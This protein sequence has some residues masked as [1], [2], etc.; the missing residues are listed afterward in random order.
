MTNPYVWS[1]LGVLLVLGV[2][3]Y[4]ILN[5]WIMPSYTRHGESISVPDVINRSYEEAN[6]RL[7]RAGLLTEQVVLRKPNL[8]RGV[9]IDQNPEPFSNVKPGRRIYLTVNSG[10]TALVAVPNVLNHSVREARNRIMI[11][12]LTVA[13]VRPD[14]IPSA[15]ANTITRQSPA[16]GQRVPPESGVVLWYSTGLGNRLVTIPRVTGMTIAEARRHLLRRRLRSVV[17]RAAISSVSGSTVACQSP[18]EG[19]TVLEGFE[20]RLYVECPEGQLP[21]DA[22]SLSAG[23]PR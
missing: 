8:P 17:P 9:V 2:L 14:S 12:G 5:S 18:A 7:E 6:E 21:P 10:D 22:D 19:A 1:G 15:H 13:D 11:Q 20:I 4:V 16:A 3:I 23:R